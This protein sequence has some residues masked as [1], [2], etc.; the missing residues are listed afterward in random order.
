MLLP[1]PMNE[2]TYLNTRIQSWIAGITPG[3]PEASHR[4]D[5]R[6]HCGQHDNI[7]NPSK[8]QA[9]PTSRRRA[10]APTSGNT[11]QQPSDRSS[12][13]RRSPRRPNPPNLQHTTPRHGANERAQTLGDEQEERTPRPSKH[14]FAETPPK[15]SPRKST[16]LPVRPPPYNGPASVQG[17]GFEEI[18]SNPENV[19]SSS[20]SSDSDDNWVRS[21]SGSLRTDSQS[22]HTRGGTSSTRSRS[23]VKTMADLRMAE[24][25]TEP[26]GLDGYSASKAGGI[27]KH[28]CDLRSISLGEGVIPKSLKVCNS[29]ECHK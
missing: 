9:S 2:N 24:R 29:F 6:K 20:Q 28:Y 7:T 26:V 27:L 17:G 25:A 4:V 19:R 3:T 5:K 14:G 22:D 18:P 10:L 12:P 1:D 11:M 23:P 21:L 8:L 16:Q 15:L 13:T